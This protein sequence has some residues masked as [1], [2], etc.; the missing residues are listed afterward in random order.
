ML[1]E[2]ASIMAA[3]VTKAATEDQR[4]KERAAAGEAGAGGQAVE[5]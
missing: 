5:P 1:P 4:Q 2:K 3:P